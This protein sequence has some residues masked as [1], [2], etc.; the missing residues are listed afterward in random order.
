MTSAISEAISLHPHT[1]YIPTNLTR[2]EGAVGGCFEE[3]TSFQQIII[4]W[5]GEG[6]FSINEEQ[7]TVSRGSILMWNPPSGSDWKL[8][9]LSRLQGVLVGYRCLTT[10]GSKPLVIESDGHYQ[11]CS[12]KIIRL[13]REFENAWKDSRD[14]GPLCIQQLFIELLSEIYKGLKAKTNRVIPWLDQ[15]INYIDEHYNEDLTREQMAML[16]Q[17]SP[18]HFSR[19]FH[20]HIGQTFNSYLNLLRIR[21]AQQRLLL[22]TPNLNSLAKEVGYREGTYLSRKFK[23]VVGLS[24]TAYHNKS[25]RIVALNS[26]HTASLLAL[27]I[28]PILGVYSSWLEG[29][30]QV[31]SIERLNEWGN[32]AYSNF[33]DIASVDPDL[34]IN[35]NA[36]GENKALLPIAPVIGIPFMDMSWR[37]QFRLIAQIVGRQKQVEEWLNAYDKI[38]LTYNQKLNQH[39]GE[40]GTAIVWEIG[41]NSAYCFNS[42]HGRGSQILYED[43]GF[44]LP[45]SLHKKGIERWG[46]IEVEIEAIVDYPAD[47]IFITE[48]PSDPIAKERVNRLFQSDQWTDLKAI[49]SK[50]FYLIE[51]PDLFFGYDPLSSNAQLH[52]LMRLL[53]S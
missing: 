37:E 4:V 26:N 16:A 12:T 27:G 2:L 32:H 30:W 52:E 36:A 51:K 7:H 11:H 6:I 46:Y 20:M 3:A 45:I 28:T 38:I 19:A 24:P 47:H 8:I 44:S 21:T 15:V 5:G 50:Q 13:A 48:I 10:D 31:K 35:Y 25:K 39:Y 29:E 23:Q 42:S 40:R 18:E 22:D 9:S 17:V 53:T 34:I 43:L 41:A 49:R 33:E 1:F 14:R